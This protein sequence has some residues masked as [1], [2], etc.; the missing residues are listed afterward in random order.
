M[1]NIKVYRIALQHLLPYVIM[2]ELEDADAEVTLPP[3][4]SKKNITPFI[5]HILRTDNGVQMIANMANIVGEVS[6]AWGDDVFLVFHHMGLKTDEDNGLALFY[7]IMGCLGHGIGL[8][9][10]YSERL[11]Q[12]NAILKRL[13]K[14]PKP[15]DHA[16]VYHDQH[17]H[18]TDYVPFRTK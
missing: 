5:E 2:N 12:A 1:F 4:F 13:D 15:Y 14:E 10:D 18:F 6:H 9:D 16:P 8:A 7:L 3:S 17:Q 11:E